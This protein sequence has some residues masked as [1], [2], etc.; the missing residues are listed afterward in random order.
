MAARRGQCFPSLAVT[1]EV[2]P[3]REL[4]PD[5]RAAPLVEGLKRH[6]LLT[7]NQ[8]EQ[9]RSTDAAAAAM[10]PTTITT[11]EPAS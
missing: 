6:F 8:A 2:T 7:R 11:T 9:R 1:P 10:V 5:L 4:T 3:L